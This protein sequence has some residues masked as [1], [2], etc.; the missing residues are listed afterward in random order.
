MTPQATLI[1]VYRTTVL[2]LNFCLS[3]IYEKFLVNKQQKDTKKLKIFNWEFYAF[4][5]GFKHFCESFK[6]RYV[7][8][9]A[10]NNDNMLST[11]FLLMSGT[12]KLTFY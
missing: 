6:N 11:I 2:Q 8:V 12:S 10:G 1:A 3:E 4:H 7:N 5:F 9:W